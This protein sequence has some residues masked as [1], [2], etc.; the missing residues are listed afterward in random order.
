MCTHLLHPRCIAGSE[1]PHAGGN[2]LQKARFWNSS[3]YTIPMH[4][5]PNSQAA[6]AAA[7]DQPVDAP[8][9]CC[10]GASLQS[11][12]GAQIRQIGPAGFWKQRPH[13]QAGSFEFLPST[14][15]PWVPCFR[16]GGI[17]TGGAQRE[18]PCRSCAWDRMG[19]RK[20]RE[21]RRRSMEAEWKKKKKVK[22]YEEK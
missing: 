15:S 1:P 16:A 9:P 20:T 12:S 19:E 3:H 11:F 5:R 22:E 4:A 14:T 17:H 13:F 8:P 7:L 21:S 10:R 6:N 18:K 2:G